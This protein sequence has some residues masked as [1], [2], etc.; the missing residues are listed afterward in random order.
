MSPPPQVAERLH[1][2][3]EQ[4]ALMRRYL[5][6]VDREPVQL[7][8]SYWSYDLLRGTRLAESVDI[9]RTGPPKSPDLVVDP[10]THSKLVDA[11]LEAALGITLDYFFDEVSVASITPEAR[12]L[13]LPRKAPVIRIVRTYYDQSG[14][15]F[16]VGRYTLAPERNVL[17]YE[18]P[19]LG[20]HQ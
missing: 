18:V 19:V 20:R 13:G 17:F 15:P 11:E 1:L 7:S 16:E 9:P 6:L 3:A 4:V 10:G 5:L 14:Q 2:E 12:S 8:D